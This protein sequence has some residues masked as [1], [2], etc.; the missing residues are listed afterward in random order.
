MVEGSPVLIGR[1]LEILVGRER[2]LGD[3]IAAETGEDSAAQRVAAAALAAP[4]RVLYAEGS[5]LSLAGEPRAQI[6]G[7]L[8]TAAQSAFDLL[9][10]SLGD[11]G[12]RAPA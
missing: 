6:L 3:A 7:R 11:Y 2:A 8:A 4:H 1:G 12:I 10:P 5:R 9:E